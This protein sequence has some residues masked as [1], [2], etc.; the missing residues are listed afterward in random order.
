MEVKLDKHEIRLI[1]SCIPT[2]GLNGWN[3]ALRRL[4]EKMQAVE[5][6]ALTEEGRK[7]ISGAV[8]P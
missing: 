7:H 6:V 4:R 2:G 1:L 3:P 5:A 8:T